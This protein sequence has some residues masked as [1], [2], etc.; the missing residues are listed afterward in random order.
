VLVPNVCLRCPVRTCVWLALPLDN[1]NARPVLM[2]NSIVKEAEALHKPQT[3][4]LSSYF[5]LYHLS[6]FIFAPS[7]TP[8]P[9]LLPSN[10]KFR[11]IPEFPEIPNKKSIEN[12]KSY[13]S[14]LFTSLDRRLEV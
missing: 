10:S 3:T 9:S 1:L 6:P 12:L 2:Q 7:P 11:G 8:L 5:L 4:I 14:G 13:K